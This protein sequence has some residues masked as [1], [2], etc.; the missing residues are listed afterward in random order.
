M[1]T[2]PTTHN[3]TIEDT[4]SL[5][6]RHTAIFGKTFLPEI[7][8]TKFAPLH[9]QMAKKLDSNSQKIVIAAPRGLGKTSFVRAFCEKSILFRNYE[10][11]LY[12]SNAENV[13]QIQTE[14]MKRD[15]KTNPEIRK[16]FGDIQ[17]DND[18]EGIDESFS[19]TAWVAF[20][21][22]MV[23]PRGAGQQ[24]RGL[25]F[26]HY[27]PQLIIVDDLEVRDELYNTENRKKLK[28]WFHA[29]LEKCIDRYSNKWKIVYIDT[30][31]HGDSLLSELLDSSDWDPLRLELCDDNFH[32]NVPLLLSDE[33]LQREV[34]NH[35]R[36]GTIDIFYMEYR[37]LAISLE[38]RGFSQEYFKYY[39][40]ATIDDKDVESFV[41]GDPAKSVNFRSAESAVVGLSVNY[42]TGAIYVRDIVHGKMYPDQ[43]YDEIFTMRQ[44]L[45][46]MHVGIEVTGLEEFIKQPIMNEM[47]KRGAGNFFEPVW[48]KARGGPPDKEKGK[49]KRIGSLIPYY[50]QGYIYHNKANCAVLES[51]LLAFQSATLLDVADA[52]AYIIE[53]LELG[54]RYFETPVVDETDPEDEFRELNNDY[55]APLTG[56]RQ[57]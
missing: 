22:T 52:T 2:S 53:M 51:Q 50:R 36:N 45:K 21:T 56:W 47:H 23:L 32:S 17:L 42:R 31:K 9:L 3:L 6:N 24:V 35:R 4:L 30:L 37:N 5:C 44:R 1:A 11:I 13:A 41:I 10:F 38:N 40:P 43:F 55:D 28:D 48:L 7:F 15:M 39:D 49:I 33:E 8:S 25:L 14:N 12:V 19:K 26:K 27:R 34:E 29:D 46:A 18:V 54:Q 16:F 20:G 57:F